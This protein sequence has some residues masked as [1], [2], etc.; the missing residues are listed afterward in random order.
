MY[1]FFGLMRHTDNY[2]TMR[3]EIK[4]GDA[5]TYTDHGMYRDDVMA[6]IVG[7]IPPKSAWV[8][9]SDTD[10]EVAWRDIIDWTPS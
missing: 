8:A 5:I 9:L 7:F 4:V 3:R 1:R 2:L 10:E 6:G